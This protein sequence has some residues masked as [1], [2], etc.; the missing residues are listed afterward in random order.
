MKGEL[1][2]LLKGNTIKEEIL[3][4]S[5]ST[6]LTKLKNEETNS[7]VGKDINNTYP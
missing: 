3:N 2:K 1:I 7:Q 4:S 6:T 5:T